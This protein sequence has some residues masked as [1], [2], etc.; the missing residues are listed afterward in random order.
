MLGA[1]NRHPLFSSKLK[2]ENKNKTKKRK[3][4]VFKM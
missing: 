2:K 3:N 4:L 1:I